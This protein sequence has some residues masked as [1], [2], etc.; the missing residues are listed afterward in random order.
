MWGESAST[1]NQTISVSVQCSECYDR[2]DRNPWLKDHWWLW[3]WIVE[4]ITTKDADF[5]EKR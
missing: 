5:G 3:E 4:C 1:D 2:K